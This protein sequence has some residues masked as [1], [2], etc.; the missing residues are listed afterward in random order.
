GAT[1]ACGFTVVYTGG[2]VDTDRGLS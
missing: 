2:G 1:I